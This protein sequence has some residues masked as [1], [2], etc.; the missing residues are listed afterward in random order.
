[1]LGAVLGVALASAGEVWVRYPGRHFPQWRGRGGLVGDA[2]CDCT[3]HHGA[4]V[5]GAIWA[6]SAHDGELVG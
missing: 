2:I 6:L 1:M 5:G 4:G 3:R